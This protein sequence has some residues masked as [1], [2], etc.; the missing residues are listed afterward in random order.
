M[1]NILLYEGFVSIPYENVFSITDFPGWL[2][3]R[4]LFA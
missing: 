2:L 3:P 4:P 1:N